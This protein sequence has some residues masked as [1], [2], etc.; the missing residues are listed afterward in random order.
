M[1]TKALILL[2]AVCLTAGSTSFAE[3]ANIGKWEMKARRE[4]I[5]L[6]M[7]KDITITC[8]PAFPFRV[9]VISEGID[10]KGRPVHIEWVGRFNGRDYAVTGDPNSDMRS[11]TKVDDHTLNFAMKKSGKVVGRGQIVVEPDGRRR[12]VDAMEL[13][14]KGRWVKSASLCGLQ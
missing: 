12:T 14:A 10:A 13:T 2:L 11:Y 8:A 7:G 3:N 5:E 6:G 9:K 1:N 4:Q